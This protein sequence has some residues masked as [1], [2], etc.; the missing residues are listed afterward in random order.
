MNQINGNQKM[1]KTLV[2]IAMLAF[3][4]SILGGA[5]YLIEAYKWNVMTMVLAIILIFCNNP[6][7]NDV[8]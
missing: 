8:L 7:E 2:Y 4:F 6:R 5:A 3:D 1:N